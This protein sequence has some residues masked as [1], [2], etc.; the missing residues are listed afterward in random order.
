MRTKFA[1]CLVLIL[2]IFGMIGARAVESATPI[3]VATFNVDAS[4]PIGAPLAYD[5]TKGIQTPLSCRGI[6]ILSDQKP[7]ILVSVDWIGIASGGQ[8]VFKEAL[9]QAANTDVNR[10]TIHTIHQHDAPRCDFDADA[11]LV[12]EGLENAGFDARHARSVVQNAAAALKESLDSATVVTHVGIGEGTVKDVASNRRIM[13]PDGKVLHTR[14]TATRDPKIRE[15]PAGTIDPKLKSI[16]FW[17]KDRPLAVLTYYATHPQSYY[18]TGLANPDFPGIA[19]NAQEKDLQVTHI[20]FNGAGGNIGAGKWNDGSQSNRQV[21]ADKVQAGMQEAWESTKK[22]SINSDDLLWKTKNVFLPMA[23]HL[24]EEEL[25]AKVNNKDAKADDR[26]YAAKHLVWLRRCESKD[27]IQISCLGIK[28]A[29]VLHMPGEMF[30]EYQLAAQKMAPDHFVAMAAYGD[31][32]PGYVCTD[33]AYSQGGYES[34]DRASRVKPGVE[35]I[36]MDA[37]RE[38]LVK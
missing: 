30:V 2:L 13:G 15:F 14:Y 27:P 37:M 28:Q 9:A 22:H 32:A 10:I 29:R 26:W 4:P 3:K 38:L 31:Y 1:W 20:H 25:V 19:R 17:N 5:P 18:R 6:V 16:S 35:K 12:A 23:D 8:T 33:I 21:L 36:L 7:I 34:S 11:L 24:V